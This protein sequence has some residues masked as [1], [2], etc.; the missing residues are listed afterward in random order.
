[1]CTKS[2]INHDL[3][4]ILNLDPN[5]EAAQITLQLRELKLKYV[6]ILI[7]AYPGITVID[8]AHRLRKLD[9]D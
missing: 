5:D 9:R 4:D 8:I 2:Y 7:Q 3:M 1:M 6:Y